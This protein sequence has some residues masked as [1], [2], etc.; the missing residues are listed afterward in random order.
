MEG[1]GEEDETNELKFMN[2]LSG[3]KKW[4][5]IGDYTSRGS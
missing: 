2:F 3:S 1:G 5:R 4:R